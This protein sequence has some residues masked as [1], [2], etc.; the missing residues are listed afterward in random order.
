MTFL[1]LDVASDESVGTVAQQVRA[2]GG[3][4]ESLDREYGLCRIFA[5]ALNRHILSF[6]SAGNGERYNDE[7][8]HCGS[9]WK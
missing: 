7:G 3:N 9:L 6:L 8:I 2:V 1:G 5:P 4:S